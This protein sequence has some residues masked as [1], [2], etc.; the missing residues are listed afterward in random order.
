MKPLPE[1]VQTQA[2][3]VPLPETNHNF[4]LDRN[5]KSD[6]DQTALQNDTKDF[7]YDTEESHITL[8]VL[9]VLVMERHTVETK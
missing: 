4:A 7:M 3:P 2:G 5:T 8:R 1:T 9:W 6:I